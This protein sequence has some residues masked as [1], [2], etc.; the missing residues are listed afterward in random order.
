M[1]IDS[2]FAVLM[3]FALFKGWKNGLIVAVFSFISIFI[4]L[5]AAVK[6]SALVAGWLSKS[7][8]VDAKWLP[9]LSFIVVMIGVI[10][11]VRLGAKLIEKTLTVAML[12]WA[13]RLGG[14]LLY[15]VLYTSIFSVILFYA[16]QIGLLKPEAVSASV[17]YPYIQNWG[18]KAIEYF[19][20]VMPFL[21]DSFTELEQFFGKVAAQAK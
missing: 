10:L 5:A 13:N 16:K 11:L 12:G 8:T 4:G 20:V 2:L 15:A 9:F 6:C 19:G 3:V 18:P 14:I 1:V 17:I 7:T 21:K